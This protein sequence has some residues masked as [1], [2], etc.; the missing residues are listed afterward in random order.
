MPFKTSLGEQRK[1][2]LEAELARIK[3]I[4]PTLNIQKAILFGSLVEGRAGK[5]SDIDLILVSAFIR[6]ALATGE[7]S[8]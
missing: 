4:L 6:R 8:L 1:R 2:R 7:G 3:P 5:I